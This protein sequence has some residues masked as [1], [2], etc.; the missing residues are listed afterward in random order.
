MPFDP[1][2]A[3]RQASINTAQQGQLILMM[4]EGAMNHLKMAKE[5]MV[6]KDIAE[7]GKHLTKVISIISALNMALNEEAGGEIAKNLRSLY[8]FMTRHLTEA[9]IQNSPKHLDD[10]LKVLNTLYDGWRTIIVE[11]RHEL[12][13]S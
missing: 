2:Q 13:A 8:F 4:Y 1:L 10:V 3:Y 9:N 11:R 7:K 6:Q 12:P 5:K